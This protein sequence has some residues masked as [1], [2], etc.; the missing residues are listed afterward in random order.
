VR[1]EAQTLIPRETGRVRERPRTAPSRCCTLAAVAALALAGAVALPASSDAAGGCTDT[2]VGASNAKWS[3]AAN[4]SA[5]RV[6]TAED[7]VCIPSGVTASLWFATEVP[8][9]VSVRAIHGG[10]LITN[11]ELFLTGQPRE[12]AS[13]VETLI[14][15]GTHLGVEGHGELAVS[16]E[17][18]INA[19]SGIGGHGT[20]TLEPGAVGE[21]GEIGC[22]SLVVKN[23]TIINYGTL[24]VGRR[25]VGGELLGLIGQAQL[26]N[27]GTLGID[28]QLDE[29]EDCARDTAGATIYRYAPNFPYEGEAIK[30][31]GT[32]QTEWGE[33]AAIIAVPVT[34]DGTIAARE[35]GLALSDGTVASECSSG[36]W[37][38]D[39][40]PLQLATGA[41][42][43][44]PGTS[45]SGV[46]VGGG[47]TLQGCPSPITPPPGGS[48]A[49]PSPPVPSTPARE[50]TPALEP[51]AAGPGGAARVAVR[52][53][54]PRITVGASLAEVRR[55]LAAHG[56]RVGRIR[57]A[58]RRGI[59]A[60]HAIALEAKVGRSLPAGARI[61]LVMAVAAH[62]TSTAK[63]RR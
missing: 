35:G 43:L 57:Y 23:T 62:R 41:F 27:D 20:I 26:I 51:D 34:N 3:I 42:N 10:S 24:H 7:V 22:G 4:W 30:N 37:E 14:V 6:P 15:I 13:S 18:F 2:F 52:C 32:I 47:A 28:T 44:A 45:L 56:C 36:R 11:T 39:G 33:H 49:G 21:L 17:L 25:Y 29:R 1:K 9:Y 58:L 38:S 16:H 60:G 5:G 55:E 48:P 40:A 61:T 59:A 54:V 12:Y 31:N 50:T 8:D 63:S 53:V 46:V 19:Q